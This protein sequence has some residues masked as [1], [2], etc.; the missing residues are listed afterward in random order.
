MMVDINVAKTM[1]SAPSPS[2]HHFRG[3]MLTFP[4]WV[5]IYDCFTHI[6]PLSWDG[7][8]PKEGHNGF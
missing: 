7:Y 1:P 2:H 4:K 5:F 3:G 8:S 6:V